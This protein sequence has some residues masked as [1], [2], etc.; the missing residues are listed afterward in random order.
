MLQ[1]N[2]AQ[3]LVSA[4]APEISP[5]LDSAQSIDPGGDDAAPSVCPASLLTIAEESHSRVHPGA[6]QTLI[7][8]HGPGTFGKHSNRCVSRRRF[9]LCRCKLA[10]CSAITAHGIA[11]SI[12]AP[13]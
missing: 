13:G 8:K 7:N 5:P 10:A 2:S 12:A 9:R 11:L 6:I 3:L 4:H 1:S